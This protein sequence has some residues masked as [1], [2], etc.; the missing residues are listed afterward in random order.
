MAALMTKR[1]FFFKFF[2]RGLLPSVCALFLTNAAFRNFFA[3][4]YH[5]KSNRQTK[6]PFHI[7]LIFARYQFDEF[8]WVFLLSR[9]TIEVVIWKCFMMKNK[10]RIRSSPWLSY[11]I[12]FHH[13]NIN[14]P[15]YFANYSAMLTLFF[16]HRS[17]A[18]TATFIMGRREIYHVFCFWKMHFKKLPSQEKM[19]L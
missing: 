19:G 11:F 12:T 7:F 13:E 10:I 3:S 15:N 2:V 14:L 4:T 6:T 5:Q 18:A 17:L 16:L 1:F 8:E 9:W